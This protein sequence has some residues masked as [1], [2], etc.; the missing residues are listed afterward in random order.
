MSY[1]YPPPQSFAADA[2]YTKPSP[3]SLS[4]HKAQHVNMGFDTRVDPA[5]LDSPSLLGAAESDEDDG[6]SPYSASGKRGASSQKAGTS[7]RTKLDD[8]EWASEQS[9]SKAGPREIKKRGSKACT[10]CRRLKMKCQDAE[11]GPPCKRCSQQGL[12]C[13]FEESQR[14]D[15]AIIK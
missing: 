3:P 9:T 13:I 11:S 10:V 8:S 6:D 4:Q 15:S 1:S 7:K 12:E 2:N 14:C 5:L